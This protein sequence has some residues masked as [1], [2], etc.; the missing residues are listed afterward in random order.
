MIIVIR[1]FVDITCTKTKFLLLCFF[2]ISLSSETRDKEIVDDQLRCNSLVCNFR[3]KYNFVEERRSRQDRGAKQLFPSDLFDNKNNSFTYSFFFFF[4]IPRKSLETILSS[5]NVLRVVPRSKYF[6][7]TRNRIVS[8]PN[9][10]LSR[11]IV[12]TTKRYLNLVRERFFV[13]IF[14]S[15][16]FFRFDRFFFFTLNN[17]GKRFIHQDQY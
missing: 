10:E 2:L 16:L 17:N 5:S 6:A 9:S 15:F 11:S 1:L 8:F 14:L 7:K 3:L 13:L 12:L 4:Y